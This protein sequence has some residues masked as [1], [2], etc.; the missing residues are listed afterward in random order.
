MWFVPVGVWNTG[1]TCCVHVS[2]T[3]EV[4][5]CK[6]CHEWYGGL[7]GHMRRKRNREYECLREYECK[8][9]AIDAAVLENTGV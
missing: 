9:W 2:G 6:D 3:Q 1:S 4:V 7:V 8:G 5:I